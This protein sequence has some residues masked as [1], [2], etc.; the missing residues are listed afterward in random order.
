M[1]DVV[2]QRRA[3]LD[4]PNVWPRYLKSLAVTLKEHLRLADDELNLVWVRTRDE[5]LDDRVW[6][7]RP[8]TDRL[9]RVLVKDVAFLQEREMVVLQGDQP[10]LW[11]LKTLYL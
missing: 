3:V 8:M 9:A 6:K 7:Q 2:F 4:L 11:D 5:S 10:Q 1:A